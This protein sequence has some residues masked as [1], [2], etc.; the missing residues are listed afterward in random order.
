MKLM[1]G[2]WVAVPLE[3]GHWS[4]DLIAR[5][6]RG[7]VLLGYFFGPRSERKPDLNDIDGLKPDD[8][9]LIGLI[10]HLGIKNQ[11]W[12]VIGRT[13]NF[14]RKDWPLPLFVRRDSLI[15]RVE[16]V[17]YSDDDLSEVQARR[18]DS[19][20][21]AGLPEDGLMGHLFVEERLSDLLA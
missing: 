5:V 6:S 9:V 13:G 12:P 10:G 14:V 20:D 8:A 2:E 15:D 7:G 18:V 4:I 21:V 1:G 17:R 11:T 19:R 3:G 16:L